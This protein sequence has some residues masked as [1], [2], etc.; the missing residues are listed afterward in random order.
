MPSQVESPLEVMRRFGANLMKM[1][2]SPTILLVCDKGSEGKAKLAGVDLVAPNGS[3]QAVEL[4]LEKLR[5]ARE[6]QR[7]AGRKYKPSQCRRNRNSLLIPCFRERNPYSSLK[8]LNV[9]GLPQCLEIP[10]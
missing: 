3:R 5:I 2:S 7:R 10:C 4:G 6:A 1:V 8:P 9:N